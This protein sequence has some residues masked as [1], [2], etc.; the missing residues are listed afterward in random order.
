MIIK[1]ALKNAYLNNKN[2]D[3]YD[4]D[5]MLA[6]ALHK[7]TEYLHT[8]P[9]KVVPVSAFKKFAH[10]IRQRKLGYSIANL[11][12]FKY[13][14]GHKFL[15]NKHTLIPRPDSEILVDEV[16]KI[17]KKDDNIIDIGTGSGCLI[18]SIAREFPKATFTACDIS[19]Q[20]LATARTNARKLGLKHII[21]FK[22]SNLLHDIDG[23]YDIILANLPYLTKEQMKE[24]SIK[25]EPRSALLSGKDG[26]D[27]YRQLLKQIPNNLKAKF[28]IFLE[29]DPAQ[30]DAIKKMI[31]ENLPK[32]K[33]KFIKDLAN[34][35][36]VVK[37]SS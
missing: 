35:T 27:H 7:R 3:K 2:L 31:L 24:S 15:V 12:G 23:Q 9:E 13:F 16:L 17:I 34:N 19:K 14:Y 29:I 20:A 6:L 10:L 8:K 11:Q 1:D 25:K 5:I 28:N 30:K 22:H 37:I 36:R 4:I 21:T 26:L 18:L 32:A 33:I